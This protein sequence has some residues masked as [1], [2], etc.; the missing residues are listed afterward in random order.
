MAP[1]TP[2]PPS[3]VRL[4]AFTIASSENVVMSATQMSSRVDPICAD[5]SGDTLSINRNV[6]RPLGLR[7]GEEIHR[8]LDADIVEMVVE[9]P[10]R[11][12]HAIDAQRFEKSVIG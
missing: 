1:S 9:E 6:S 11:G 10:A 12:A 7:F 2:P 3:N 8:T 4:A 5:K